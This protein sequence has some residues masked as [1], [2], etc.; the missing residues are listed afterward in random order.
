MG[1]VTSE[2]KSEKSKSI[3]QNIQDPVQHEKKK[4]LKRKR[5][6]K[7]SYSY[8]NQDSET[9]ADQNRTSWFL[10]GAALGVKILGGKNILSH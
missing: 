3:T 4:N 2:K 6:K 9:W 7:E 5:F 10:A 8:L 1:R